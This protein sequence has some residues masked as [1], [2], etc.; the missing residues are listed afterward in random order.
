MLFVLH[1]D[2]QTH[3]QDEENA[4]A[5]RT[6]SYQVFQLDEMEELRPFLPIDEA[7][8]FSEKESGPSSPIEAFFGALKCVE[9]SRGRGEL[10]RMA[11]DI[12]KNECKVKYIKS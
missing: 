11:A 9:S 12:L 5:V 3:F 2:I 8:E 10:F 1:S 4:T 6:L 7:D